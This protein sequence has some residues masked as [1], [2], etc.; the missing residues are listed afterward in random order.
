[1]S[2]DKFGRYTESGVRSRSYDKEA[3]TGLP[4]TP[5]GDYNISNKRLRY[6]NDPQDSSD[7]INLKTLHSKISNSLKLEK[8]VYNAKSHKIVNIPNPENEHDVVNKGYVDSKLEQTIS[9]QGDAFVQGEMSY[10]CLESKDNQ[11]NGKKRKIINVQQAE[12]PDE[13]PVMGQTLTRQGDVFVLGEN[14]YNFLELNNNN[15]DAKNHTISNLPAGKEDGDAVNVSQIPKKDQNY[16]DFFNKRL[17]RVKPARDDNDCVTKH[18]TIISDNLRFE[19]KFDGKNKQITNILPGTSP[20]DVAIVDQILKYKDGSLTQGDNAYE[21]LESKED[22]WD[23]KKKKIGNLVCGTSFNDAVCVSQIPTSN[24]KEWDF[25]YKRLVNVKQGIGENDCVTTSQTVTVNFEDKRLDAKNY[26]ITNVKAGENDNDC[27]IKSQTVTLNGLTFDGKN[28]QLSNI[29]PGIL[30]NDVTV[31]NQLLQYDGGMLKQGDNKYEFLESKENNW[32]AKNKKII[33]VGDGREST[34][35]VCLRQVPLL[36]STTWDMR[37]RRITNVERAILADDCVIK[38]QTITLTTDKTDRQKRFDA[39]NYPLANVKAGKND[40]DC[41][42]K[43]QTITL[44]QD[45]FNANNK[46]IT[47]TQQGV[48]PTDVAVVGQV[49]TKGEKSVIKQGDK[50]YN[51]M[52]FDKEK[53]CWD[54]EKQ[55]IRNL[56]KGEY[57]DDICLIS[58][59][60]WFDS[61]VNKFKYGPLEFNLMEYNPNILV[62]DPTSISGFKTLDGKE[63]HP[64][65]YVYKRMSDGK[66]IDTNGE[67]FTV[68]YDGAKGTVTKKEGTNVQEDET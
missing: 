46:Q 55:F 64:K 67:T 34:D 21:F 51:V 13:V 50:E 32:D 2:V 53:Q 1:M 19:G 36:K 14:K 33:N 54:A 62:A 31:V 43:S 60:V 41:V 17:V 27:V 15:W 57:D 63:Y 7:A 39:R 18:Q 45:K 16:W 9:R 28:K 30:P 35:A 61:K 11:W 24:V 5:E 3:H 49:L 38:E 44:V 66:L 37:N 59:A 48:L 26:P 10:E 12:H 68:T 22:K 4:L 42:V 56:P 25:N 52:M 29:L 23:G 65:N 40:N 47:N 20:S 6:V 8:D 58:Q